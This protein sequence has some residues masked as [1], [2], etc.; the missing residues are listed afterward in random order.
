MYPLIVVRLEEV[1][2]LMLARFSQQLNAHS[3]IVV[4][5]G[6]ND[7]DIRLAQSANAACPI[8]WMLFGIVFVCSLLHLRNTLFTMPEM[9]EEQMQ[10]PHPCTVVLYNKI[11]HLCSDV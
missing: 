4:A 10:P 11:P 3:C 6:G 8:V 1:R 2:M 9:S 7:M 5:D